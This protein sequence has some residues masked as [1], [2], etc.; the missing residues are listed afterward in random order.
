MNTQWSV[1]FNSHTELFGEDRAGA[2]KF[3]VGVQQSLPN[4]CV[5]LIGEGNMFR[6]QYD[7][8]AMLN[9]PEEG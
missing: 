4:A 2:K 7:A 3:A 9:D 5:W 8:L 6:V 1:T